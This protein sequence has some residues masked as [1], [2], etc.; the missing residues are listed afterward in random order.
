MNWYLNALRNFSNFYGRSSRTE[1]WM[2]VLFNTMFAILFYSIDIIFNL[3]FEKYG[4]GPLYLL[5][6]IFA[7][8][9]GLALSVRRLH[10]V[11]RNGTFILISLLP[12]IGAI[13]LLILF[14]T[15]GDDEENE[16][17]EKPNNDDIG[18]FINNDKTN[19]YLIVSCL[20]WV[21]VN[22]I[23]WSVTTRFLENFYQNQ[24]FKQLMELFSL[25]WIFFPVMLSL[26][27]KRPKLKIIFLILS[28][29]YLVYGFYEIVKSH[30]LSSDNFQF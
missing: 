1:Y 3:N 22:K 18:E 16:Y 14:L 2:F 24:T 10:D 11:G 12:V 19:L 13:W 9:P 15:K 26:T 7:F 4:F 17:G 5:Y 28:M 20:I 21:F 29:I 6:V 8:I 23:F 25:T 27:I 30:I